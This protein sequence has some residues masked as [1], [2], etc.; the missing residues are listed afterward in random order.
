MCRIRRHTDIPELHVINLFPQQLD[1]PP[2]QHH[3]P[4]RNPVVETLIGFFIVVI[5][6]VWLLFLLYRLYNI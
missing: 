3:L 6:H 1:E 5:I 2:N 4:E